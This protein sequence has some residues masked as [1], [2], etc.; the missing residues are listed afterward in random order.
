MGVS[1]P[2]S[3]VNVGYDPFSP[4]MVTYS[5]RFR[6]LV[7]AGA[8]VSGPGCTE[9]KLVTCRCCCAF[10]K[11]FQIW[12]LPQPAGQFFLLCLDCHE[13]LL[14]RIEAEKHAKN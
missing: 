9:T 2:R 8:K 6:F 1:F 10:V 5:L 11:T 12:S 7:N 4:S 3:V 14:A 13:E